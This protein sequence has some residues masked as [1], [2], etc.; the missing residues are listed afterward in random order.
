[1]HASIQEH[2]DG[3]DPTAV[4]A[5]ALLLRV[6]AIQQSRTGAAVIDEFEAE[7]E[8]EI[9]VPMFAWSTATAPRRIGTTGLGPCI[10]I[11]ILNDTSASARVLHS[12]NMRHAEDDLRRY[13]EGAIQGDQA[14]DLVRVILVGGDD[15]D[16]DVG[17]EVRADREFTLATV[18]EFFGRQVVKVAW[19]QATNFML[20][21]LDGSWRDCLG[22]SCFNN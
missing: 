5:D 10:G 22:S 12:P 21:H 18:R 9:D 6:V 11:A 1:M 14:G 16:P 15:N 20:E 7:G 17:N 8:D 13:L 4:D 2:R 19:A 3:L